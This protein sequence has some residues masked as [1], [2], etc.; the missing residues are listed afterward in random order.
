VFVLLFVATMVSPAIIALE[1]LGSHAG[2]C[3]SA[4]V[5]G[6][7]FQPLSNL[8]FAPVSAKKRP[9]FRFPEKQQNFL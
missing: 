7:H 3:K 6:R 9:Y 8:L 1:F 5:S 4:N 2:F